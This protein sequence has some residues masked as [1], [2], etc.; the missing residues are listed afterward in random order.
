MKFHIAKSQAQYL[1]ERKE[2]LDEKTCIILLDFA[3]NYHYI[4]Q[5]EVQGYHWNKEQCMLHHVVMYFKDEENNLKCTSIC[6][7]SD[8]LD[9]NT[10]FV[11]ELQRITSE[12]IKQNNEQIEIFHYCCDGCAG[13]YKS[14]KNFLNLC[15]HKK[16]FGV[17]ALW[18]FFC[19]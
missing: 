12:Y 8:D 9:H 6:F 17:H 10:N 16:D 18:S 7:L 11:H 2:N 1:K 5:D 15:Y 19:N 4:V 3:E 14:F 13:Q